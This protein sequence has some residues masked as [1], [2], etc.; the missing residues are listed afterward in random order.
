CQTKDLPA[1]SYSSDAQI[2]SYLLGAI[3]LQFFSHRLVRLLLRRAR[4]ALLIDKPML[5]SDRL[6]DLR[7]SAA[8]IDHLIIAVG[9]FLISIFDPHAGLIDDVGELFRV[10]G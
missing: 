9:N 5:R 7:L 6:A 2:R 8:V 3:H 4:G 10:I 1:N